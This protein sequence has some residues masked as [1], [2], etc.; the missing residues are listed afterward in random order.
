MNSY[1]LYRFGP[2]NDGNALMKPELGGKGANLAEMAGLGIPVPPGFTLPCNLSVMY[3]T[4]Q[5]NTTNL[6]ELF[7]QVHHEVDNLSEILGYRP[8]MSVRSGARVSM[9]GMMD[10][11]LNVGLTTETLPYWREKLG[12]R[13]AL[14]SYR[15]LIQMY[16]SVALEVP[17]ERFEETLHAYKEVAGVAEDHELPVDRLELMVADFLQIVIDLGEEFPDTVQ[18]Q[19]EGAVLA[20]F[21][22]WMNPRA[23]E[24]RKINNIPEDWG[25]AV[26][27]QSMVFGNL[28]DQSA[29]GVLFSRDP[30]T[31]ENVITGEYLVNAQG[32]DVV[33]GIRTPENITGMADW[34]SDVAEELWQIVWT[35]EE[36]Y[37]DMQDIEFTVQSGKLY[38]LQT[39]SGKRSAKAAFQI[40]HDMLLVEK[41]ITVEEAAKRVTIEQLMALMQDTIDPS[42]NVKP[43]AVGIAAGGGLVA[44]VAM[45]NND[46][47][48]NCTEPCILVRKETDPDD[49]G[50]MHKSLGILTATG[51]L[52]SHAAVVARGM[53]KSCVVGTTTMQVGANKAVFDSA[54]NKILQKGQKVTID[55]ATGNIWVGVDV[56]VIEG[57]ANEEVLALMCALK[58][59]DAYTRITPVHGVS[60]G[61]LTKELKAVPNGRVYLDTALMGT[62]PDEIK[63]SMWVLVKCLH[64]TA[65]DLKSV[66]IDIT[67]KPTVY[68]SG[69]RT[70]DFMFGFDTDDIQ[71]GLMSSI[72][73]GLQAFTYELAQRCVVKANSLSPQDTLALKSNGFKFASTTKVK[74]FK[75]LLEAD[76]A[77]E[78]DASAL[79]NVFGDKGAWQKAKEMVEKATGKKFESGL[80]SRPFYWY[81]MTQ[82]AI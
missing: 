70:L 20:V 6:P 19:I 2:V 5:L 71:K 11:I 60:V 28:D 16:A 77:V 76:G 72:V 17:M 27:I 57:G 62:T 31:G 81:E 29:T 41:V 33:A 13:A 46:D 80:T 1:K 42:F 75:D 9:P 50:G 54:N 3:Q 44:G 40:A 23:I 68:D 49:I 64:G 24:Y 8:L 48:I 78:V 39:R 4:G 32:E 55:G 21:K 69:D 15:R 36:H 59:E 53:N 74:T 58:G 73:M 56:P 66:I 30:A 34:N 63:A 38:L 26:T 51:G 52:T 43:D 61:D 45:F 7:H 67:G 14:D 25:T 18:E 37:K 65:D 47:A 82:G 35:L 22:S 79:S 10:T 12:D